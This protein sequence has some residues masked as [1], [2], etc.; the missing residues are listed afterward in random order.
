MMGGLG[1]ELDRIF[2]GCAE[3]S[4]LSTPSFA[5]VLVAQVAYPD[6]VPLAGMTAIAAG[7]IAIAAFRSKRPDVG[8]WPRRG[9]L[10]SIPFRVVYF[11]LLYFAAS[12]GVASVAVSVGTLWL[13]PLGGLLQVLGLAVFPTVYRIAHGE[14]VRTP[15]RHV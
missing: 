4:V 15:T 11:S 7:S 8:A 14:P 3:L 13:T 2:F 6:A 1:A 5:V 9:E 12:M 10:S